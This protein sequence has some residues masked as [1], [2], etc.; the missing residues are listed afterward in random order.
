MRRQRLHG[1]DDVLFRIGLQQ[2]SERA[3]FEHAPDQHLLIVHREDENLYARLAFSDL[4]RRLD[5]VDERE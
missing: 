1:R 4:S 5:S 3:G 2:V